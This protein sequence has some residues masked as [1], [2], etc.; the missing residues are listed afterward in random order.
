MRRFFV[1]LSGIAVIAFVAPFA[2]TWAFD[3]RVH[4]QPLITI[5]TYDLTLGSGLLPILENADAI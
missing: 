2:A 3:S 1:T 5:S 4:D